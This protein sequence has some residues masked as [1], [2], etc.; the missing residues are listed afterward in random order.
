LKTDASN[1]SSKVVHAPSHP[2]NEAP[3]VLAFDLK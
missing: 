3:A 2:R 1:I